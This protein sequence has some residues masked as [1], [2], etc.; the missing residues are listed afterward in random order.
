MNTSTLAVL[1]PI[2]FKVSQGY[3]ISF[4]IKNHEPNF[5]IFKMEAA[6][7]SPCTAQVNFKPLPI[8][9]LEATFQRRVVVVATTILCR[10]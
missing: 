7:M 6:V 8:V 10:K 5:I 3:Y 2:N 9:F 1:F 4:F